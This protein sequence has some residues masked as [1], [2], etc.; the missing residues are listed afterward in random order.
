MSDTLLI[1]VLLM[2]KTD[3]SQI[4]F[5]KFDSSGVMVYQ[6]IKAEMHVFAF[7]PIDRLLNEQWLKEPLYK[8][9]SKSMDENSKLPEKILEQEAKNCADFLNSLESPLML[10][11]Y[12]VEAL[13]VATPIEV[14]TIAEVAKKIPPVKKKYKSKSTGST[15]S[16]MKLT[17]S[18]CDTHARKIF[19]AMVRGWKEA[20]GTVVSRKPGRIFLI[21]STKAHA[22]A[23]IARRPHNFNLA[24]LASPRGGKRAHIQVSWELGDTSRSWG[25][26]DCI[27][28]VVAQFEKTISSLPGFVKTYISCL[29]IDK[30]FKSLH[31]KILLDAMK[32]VMD[33]EA[34]AP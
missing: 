28:E 4:G 6:I 12:L 26:L 18:A 13:A 25:Y 10:G 7:K 24:V 30:E 34:K 31:T 15:A 19:E 9:H 16:N 27:P 11:G 20:G 23:K 33:A 22:T 8:K 3:G 14:Q 17:L 5:I 2:D 32:V 29:M 1:G 21:L